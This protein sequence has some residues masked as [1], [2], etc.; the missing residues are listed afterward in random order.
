MTAFKNHSFISDARSFLKI[1]DM[2]G[3]RMTDSTL[4]IAFYID[5][6]RSDQPKINCGQTTEA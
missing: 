4:T 6:A 5:M 1:T 2:Y 3:P